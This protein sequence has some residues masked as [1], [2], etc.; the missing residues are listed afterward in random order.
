VSDATGDPATS[1]GAPIR[2]VALGSLAL[3]VGVLVY[4]TD[5]DPSRAALIPAVTAWAGTHRFGPLG[6]WLPSFAHPF[7]F[8]L[9]TAA[10]A[11]PRARPAYWACGMWWAVNVAFEAAQ[12]PELGAAAAEA[13]QRGLGRTW[14]AN[15]LSNYVLQGT[16]DVADLAATT[17][18]AAAAA[19]VLHLLHLRE[20][21]HA[22]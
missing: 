22:H 16:F 18:G 10:L 7:A 21:R 13:M 17:A 6:G 12:A 9:F 11:L 8:S 14:L 4:L 2:L 3:A 5:R 20:T 1:P 15:A 19:L